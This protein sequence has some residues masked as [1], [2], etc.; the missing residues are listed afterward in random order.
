MLRLGIVGTGAMA[1]YHAKRFGGIEG[2][3][4]AAVCDRQRP[5]AL[6]FAEARGILAFDDPADMAAS[7]AVDAMSVASRDGWH[8]AP[9]LAAL[10]RGLPVFCEKPL[11]RTLEEARAMCAAA[12]AAG[13]P[14][15][16]NFSKRNGGLLSLARRVIASGDLGGGLRLELSYLQSWL[17]QDAWGPW[18]DGARWK[19]RLSESHSTH[20]ALGDLGSHLI[21]AAL[22]LAG[23]GLTARSFSARAFR[24]LSPPL[25]EAPWEPEGGGAFEAFEAR[26][27]AEGPSAVRADIAADW[28][29]EGKLDAFTA[30]ARGEAGVLEIDPERSRDSIVLRRNG[31][32][33]RE[34]PAE[35]IPSTYDR[36][37]ALSSGSQDPLPDEPIDFARGL[38]VQELIEGC[39][40]LI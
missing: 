36:F 8:R 33:E 19:W 39:A 7:G 38:A 21:D 32:A 29:A 5:R 2:A 16:V 6:A 1:E 9:V 10:G 34:L 28:R 24:D 27:S 35:A 20:G 4:V 3:R 31:E 30:G 37:V 15:L 17:L 40:N 23:E 22:L 12:T 11:A 18:R 26:L 25:G 13:A 14:A